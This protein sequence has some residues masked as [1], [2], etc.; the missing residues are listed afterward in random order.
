MNYIL[1]KVSGTNTP[2]SIDRSTGIIS[3]NTD[4]DHLPEPIKEF[5]ILHEIGHGNGNTS[6]EI[7]ADLYA[8]YNTAGKSKESLKN[9]VRALLFNLKFDKPEDY[10]RLLN[11]LKEALKIDY[12][13]FH[14][15]KAK[16]LYNFISD[17]ENYNKEINYLK[18]K[19]KNAKKYNS[20]DMLKA[21]KKLREVRN[22]KK[23][24]KSQGVRV[25]E[26]EVFANMLK[27]NFNGSDWLNAGTSVLDS[28]SDILSS[29]YGY[30]GSLAN[31][32]ATSEMSAAQI[33]IA[34]ADRDARIAEAQ[35]AAAA[36]AAAANNNTQT[37]APEKSDNKQLYWIIGGLVG[38]GL[39]GLIVYLINRQ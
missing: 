27:N 8:L 25:T 21:A 39:V 22:E 28:G 17:M 37:A 16:E 13:E 26:K 11:V 32:D 2:A 35:A 3:W 34:E 23:R 38:L 36:A 9:A 5:I 14:N 30:K 12:T 7:Q 33:R 19:I 24:L 6:D 20:D 31:A 29:I 18:N 1:K 10:K 15:H 4:Y